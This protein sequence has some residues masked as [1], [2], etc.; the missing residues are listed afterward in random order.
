MSEYIEKIIV[1]D[2]EEQR[3][4]YTLDTDAI[5]CAVNEMV[6][7]KRA[8]ANA[9]SNAGAYTDATV[10]SLYDMAGKISELVPAALNN[11][12]SYALQI[13]ERYR[14]QKP[15]SM[16]NAFVSDKS[17][18]MLPTIDTS[19]VISLDNTFIFCD[20]LF[21][22]SPL[23]LS[24]V[25]SAV[26]SFWS[27]D[28]LRHLPPLHLPQCED[29]RYMFSR[30]S[31][32]R[33]ITL[34]M[35]SVLLINEIFSHCNNLTS[36]YELDRCAPTSIHFAFYECVS[37]RQVYLDFSRVESCDYSVFFGC[38]NLRYLLIYNLGKSDCLSYDFS[39]LSYWTCTGPDL[40]WQT[41]YTY[42]YDRAAAGLEP[43]TIILSPETF[44][45]LSDEQ[46][47]AVTAKGFT[48]TSV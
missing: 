19:E 2:G 24:N 31:S 36:I 30:C 42:S 9:L 3:V 26:Q 17:L 11:C 29:A 18:V 12:F 47:A 21:F 34:D 1:D 37:L 43:A 25:T 33:E 32:L 41:L 45:I 23:D 35:P 10:E 6:D 5:V 7:G 44:A 40:P 14:D 28:N 48:L 4:L 15:T 38:Y 27:C 16:N 22:V 39:Q 13:I 8:V 20:N 46:I